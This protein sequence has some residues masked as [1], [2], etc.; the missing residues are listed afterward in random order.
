MFQKQLTDLCWWLW[1]FSLG[2]SQFQFPLAIG[3]SFMSATFHSPFHGQPLQPHSVQWPIVL[4]TMKLLSAL[5]TCP[6]WSQFWIFMYVFPV[7]ETLFSF[8]PHF[9]VSSPP[10]PISNWGH[11]IENCLLQKTRLIRV[12]NSVSPL[13]APQPLYSDLPWRRIYHSPYYNFQLVAHLLS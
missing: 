4:N 3:M 2:S 5:S 11:R 12:L 8:L 10:L 9:S 7:F 13:H 6:A 1:F